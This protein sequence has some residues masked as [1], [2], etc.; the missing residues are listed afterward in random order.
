[1]KRCRFPRICAVLLLVLR[2]VPMPAEEPEAGT[3]YIEIPPSAIKQVLIPQ[4]VYVGDRAELRCLF[5]GGSI[6]SGSALSGGP[7]AVPTDTTEFLA[8]SD[9]ITVESGRLSAAGDDYTLIFYITPW[10][11][12][13][14]EIPP[15]TAGPFLITLPPVVIRSILERMPSADIRP[16]APPMLLPGTAILVY[17]AIAGTALTMA[18]LSAALLKRKQIAGFIRSHLFAARRVRRFLKVLRRIEREGTPSAARYAL[19]SAELRRY[20]DARFV[21]AFSSATTPEME[22][23]LREYGGAEQSGYI[24]EFCDISLRIDYIRFSPEGVHEISPEE[25]RRITGSVR[26]LVSCFEEDEK[27]QQEAEDAQI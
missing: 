17:T 25:L 24:R 18:L 2:G 19:L 23:L 8:I 16:P 26:A 4:D 22:E 12:G 6:E 27:K 10:E 7:I 5:T 13:A 3:E 14:I 15:F 20:L 1:M 9:T 11:P 21:P